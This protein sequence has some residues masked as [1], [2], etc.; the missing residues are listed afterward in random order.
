[1]S[2]QQNMN[3]N[4]QSLIPNPLKAPDTHDSCFSKNLFCPNDY[5][6]TIIFFLAEY[7]PDRTV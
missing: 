7:S 5:F 4:P 2:L 1:M 3:T 6:I